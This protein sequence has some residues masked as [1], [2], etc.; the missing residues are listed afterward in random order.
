LLHRGLRGIIPRSNAR[1]DS[2]VPRDAALRIADTRASCA[3][4]KG[5]LHAQEVQKLSISQ[6]NQAGF[7]PHIVA[8]WTDLTLTIQ[9]RHSIEENA[10]L[11]HPERDYGRIGT[12]S[13][14]GQAALR[15][16]ARYSREM[17]QGVTI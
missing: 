4:G 8:S 12:L 5:L 6:L 3:G 15:K 13:A 17:S 7:L 10:Y 16:F 1:P 2:S 9:E 11:P 14:H